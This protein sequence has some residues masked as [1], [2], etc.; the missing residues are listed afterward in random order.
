MLSLHDD[1]SFG[2]SNPARGD[3]ICTVPNPG[4]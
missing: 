1:T 2:V 3:G 4:R